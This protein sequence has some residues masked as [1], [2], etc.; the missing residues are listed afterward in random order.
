[1]ENKKHEILER[2][3][4][5]LPK[6]FRPNDRW[7]VLLQKNKFYT[8]KI[9]NWI[10]KEVMLILNVLPLSSNAKYELFVYLSNKNITSYNELCAILY[11][12]VCRRDLPIT[13]A[14]FLNVLQD[15]RKYKFKL[16]T[17]IEKMSSVR[18]YY[19]YINK[20]T[21]KAKKI[22]NLSH[23]EAQRIYKIVLNYYNLIRFK[24]L[25]SSNPINLI[26]TLIYYTVREKIQPNQQKFNKRNFGMTNFVFTTYLV[27][28]L[29]EIKQK[30]LDCN[31]FE[32]LEIS[33]RNKGLVF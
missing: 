32:K 23:E 21:E 27:R 25:K 29:I 14:D 33:K 10:Y 5:I 3:I 2:N 6:R 11:D 19:W 18:K 20:L 1:M 16:C 28:F 9:H 15:D 26:Q 22:L 24:M 13:T 7:R 31:F 4:P 8:A 17:K 12:I 30:N